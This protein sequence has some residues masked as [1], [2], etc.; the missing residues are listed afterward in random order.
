VIVQKS[1]PAGLTHQAGANE[2]LKL[3]TM[4]NLKPP[5]VKPSSDGDINHSPLRG[6]E[7]EL[8]DFGG[9]CSFPD[10]GKSVERAFQADRPL[11][12]TP[13]PGFKNTYYPPSESEGFLCHHRYPDGVS[14]TEIG[15]DLAHHSVGYVRA[16]LA[17]I[18]QI[19]YHLCRQSIAGITS[20]AQLTG[21]LLARM[22][23][24]LSQVRYSCAWAER[25]MARWWS[26]GMS[27]TSFRRIRDQLEGW[28]CFTI[29]RVAPGST[30]KITP[31]S[32]VNLPRLLQVA[33]LAFQRL[34]LEHDAW[35]RLIPS[36]RCG[37]LSSLW[38]LF[39]EGSFYA[40]GGDG[41]DVGS[42]LWA[43]RAD[44]ALAQQLLEEHHWSEYLV[45]QYRAQVTTLTAQI[46]NLE[47]CIAVG[48]AV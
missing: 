39:F 27:A 15:E 5:K 37:F 3:E 35:E 18:T 48:G 23:P 42:R 30:Y 20:A 46:R 36:H 21:L 34:Q 33:A 10:Q 28:G 8:F 29:E 17:S 2:N 24:I 32:D 6:I 14:A 12:P 25:Q 19:A 40:P 38:G 16:L 45:S 44:L 26:D 31:L 47:T 7:S 43:R 4:I 9:Q 41:I 1:A 22:L 13:F 11:V